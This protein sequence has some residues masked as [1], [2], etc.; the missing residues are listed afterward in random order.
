VTS[1]FEC[2]LPVSNIFSKYISNFSLNLVEVSLSWRHHGA[3]MAVRGED[4]R[5]QYF[6]DRQI[7]LRVVT[8]EHGRLIVFSRHDSAEICGFRYELALGVGT[9]KIWLE[10]AFSCL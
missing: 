4:E 7:D 5:K 10:P 3:I 8:I 1:I 2:G 6:I 9:L